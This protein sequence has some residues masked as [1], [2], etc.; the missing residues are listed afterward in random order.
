[1][2]FLIVLFGCGDSKRNDAFQYNGHPVHPLLIKELLP[3]PESGESIGCIS[4]DSIT[5][6]ENIE[7]VNDTTT[8]NSGTWILS[9]FSNT[10]FI[11]YHFVSMYKNYYCVIVRDVDG[12]FPMAYVCFLSIQNK[13]L[14]LNGY[15]DVVNIR[16]DL[17]KV[18][19]DSLWVGS[20]KQAINTIINP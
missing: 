13:K 20:A 3:N 4:L 19:G 8:V 9:H 16:D 14:C 17:I 1:M 5:K 15:L 10:G 18:S 6:T 11:D 2:L 12:S 7:T